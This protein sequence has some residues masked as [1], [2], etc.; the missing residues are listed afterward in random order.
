MAEG[1][2]TATTADVFIPEYWATR[3]IIA[4][5][6]NLILKPLVD[7]WTSLFG[8]RGGDVVHVPCIAD[9]GDPT[10]IPESTSD[11]TATVNTE[12]N[13]S[14]TAN[15]KRY[16]TVAINN[17]ADVFANQ[18]LQAKYAEKIGYSLAQYFDSSLAAHYSDGAHDDIEFDLSSATDTNIVD[19]L[20][21]AVTN[22]DSYNVPAGQRAWV[23]CPALNIRCRKITQMASV[24]YSNVKAFAD[25]RL[26]TIH[27]IPVYTTT[28]LATATISEVLYTY[29][30]LIQK[31]AIAYAIR[32]PITMKYA[33]EDGKNPNDWMTGTVIYGTASVPNDGTNNYGIQAIRTTP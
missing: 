6:N 23:F 17:V 10:A 28:N 21:L 22:F 12:V 16:K 5:E 19:Y 26:G 24:D 30:M 18:D 8:G 7:D 32:R 20:G 14:L 27:G 2:V 3:A 31:E 9:L 1:A 15:V 4:W 29:N 33:P 11:Y 25:G 13:V